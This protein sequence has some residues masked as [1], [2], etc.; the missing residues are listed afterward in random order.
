[1]CMKNYDY[2]DEQKDVKGKVRR[3]T[4]SWCKLTLTQ[5]LIA[6][7]QRSERRKRMMFVNPALL[8]LLG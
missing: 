5:M 2:K 3:V 1:M 6:T 7:H 8:Q 4:I